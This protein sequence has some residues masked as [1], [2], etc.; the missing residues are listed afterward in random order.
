MR[1]KYFC[2]WLCQQE[3]HLKLRPKLVASCFSVQTEKKFL[4]GQQRGPF[5][6]LLNTPLSTTL[7]SVPYGLNLFTSNTIQAAQLLAV[8]VNVG[9]ID[10]FLSCYFFLTFYFFIA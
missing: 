9:D 4:S 5:Y 1:D 7:L 10:F 3:G 2:C 8:P 6:M